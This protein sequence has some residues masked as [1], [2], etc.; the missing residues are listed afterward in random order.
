M[1]LRLQS[2]R[3]VR[4]VAEHKGQTMIYTIRIKCVGGM[5]WQHSFER[6]VEIG[7]DTTFS[8]LHDLI[9]T[10]TDFDNDHCYDFF[11]GKSPHDVR[12]SLG[13]SEDYAPAS[14]KLQKITLDQVLPPPKGHK[15]F[16]W[17]DFGDDWKFE[18]TLKG[19]KEKAPGMKYPQ[20]IAEKGPKP[21]QYPQVEE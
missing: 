10:L 1:T 2:T 3:P 11:V 17:F 19:T 18:I 6:T 14:K 9:Q 20:L 13:Q 5:Y 16:Y 21:E 7:S 4:R 12:N 15:L 8:E